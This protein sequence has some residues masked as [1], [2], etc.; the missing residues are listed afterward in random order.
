MRQ[1]N[2]FQN[3]YKEGILVKGKLSLAW[4]REQLKLFKQMA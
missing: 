4:F 2:N 1:A 3:Y